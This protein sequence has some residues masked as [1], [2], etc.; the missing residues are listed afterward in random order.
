MKSLTFLLLLFV[1]ET[2]SSFNIATEKQTAPF[3]LL[4]KINNLGRNYTGCGVIKYHISV[5]GLVQNPIDKIRF[6]E[7]VV[8]IFNCPETVNKLPI[9][10]FY[11]LKVEFLNEKKFANKT[12][13][14]LEDTTIKFRFNVLNTKVVLSSQASN[15]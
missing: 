12:Y 8:L 4:V 1:F 2:G 13:P 10:Q 14:Q 15:K 9:G 11:K 6:G 3:D 5:T 7:K